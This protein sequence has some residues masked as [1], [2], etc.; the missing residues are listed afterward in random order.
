ML[1]AFPYH[2][3]YVELIRM[4]LNALASVKP[5]GNNLNQFAII[6]SGPLP[7]TSLCILDHLNKQD[8]FV[9]CHNIDQNP[10]AISSSNNVCRAL[11]HTKKAICFQCSNAKDT[12]LDLSG[13]DVVYLAALVGACGERKRDI[14]ASVV[15]R[16][17]PGAFILLRS[18]RKSSTQSVAFMSL[19]LPSLIHDK[20]SG[21]DG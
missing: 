16:M 4:E 10:E 11:G 9:T 20:M 12:N 8:Q 3:N 2:N 17:R 21:R 5:A 18:A 1:L 7:L 14:L 19:P 6:G 13:F 15:Q